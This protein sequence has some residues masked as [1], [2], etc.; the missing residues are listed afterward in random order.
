MIAIVTV[1]DALFESGSLL[2]STAID[3]S[4]GSAAAPVEPLGGAAPGV[5]VATTITVSTTGSLSPQ[6]AKTVA[7]AITEISS[8]SLIDLRF[9][10]IFRP[11]PSQSNSKF[12]FKALIQADLRICGQYRLPKDNYSSE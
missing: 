5:G 12:V 1:P 11:S 2:G 6:A 9:W 4:V 7:A 3:T 10:I 8:K